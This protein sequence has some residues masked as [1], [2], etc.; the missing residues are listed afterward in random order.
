M[1]AQSRQT[2]AMHILK[3]NCFLPVYIIYKSNFSQCVMQVWTLPKSCDKDLPVC[4]GRRVDSCRHSPSPE[5]AFQA[6]GPG[7][8]SV[9][10]HH[11]RSV[12]VFE[13][14]HITLQWVTVLWMFAC[15]K[16]HLYC[17]YTKF[18][19][20][21]HNI[22]EDHALWRWH[23][24]VFIKL[25]IGLFRISKYLEAGFMFLVP[26][27]AK[28]CTETN[29]IDYQAWKMDVCGWTYLICCS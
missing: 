12:R 7:A 17:T 25:F 15:M 19:K 5:A 28:L 22:H 24:Q 4:Q 26:D 23:F 1:I 27:V 6:P 2:T 11:P 18:I 3:S 29:R 20:N 13:H 8:S 9:D 16:K 21:V 14:N 10:G